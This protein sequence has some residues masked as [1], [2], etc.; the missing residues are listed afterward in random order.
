[1]CLT[2]PNH[3]HTPTEAAQQPDGPSIT[4]AIIRSLLVPKSGVGLRRDTATSASVHVPE[5]SMNKDDRTASWENEIG[6]S[7]KRVF[8]RFET[9]SE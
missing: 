3:E 1:M 2:F 8:V 5:A 6:S 7:R 4:Q 9:V